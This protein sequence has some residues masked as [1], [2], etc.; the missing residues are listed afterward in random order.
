MTSDSDLDFEMVITSLCAQAKEGRT[1]CPTDA[2]KA[3]AGAR[4]RG[5]CPRR[6]RD[7]RRAS[8]A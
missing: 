5:R 1:I 4:G 6:L 8:R 7:A 3:F 2:A